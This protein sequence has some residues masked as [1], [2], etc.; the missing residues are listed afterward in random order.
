MLGWPQLEKNGR[1]VSHVSPGRLALTKMTAGVDVTGRPS[2]AVDCQQDRSHR[3]QHYD[4]NCKPEYRQHT[5]HSWRQAMT[6]MTFYHGGQVCN[7]C[8]LDIGDWKSRNSVQCT[9]WTVLV[10]MLTPATRHTHKR[11][12]CWPG[13]SASYILTETT[14]VN[15]DIIDTEIRCVCVCVQAL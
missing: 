8:E 10:P 3:L 11:D 7:D 9:W 6:L 12:D 13:I 4:R 1:P 14:E 2:L 15:G 5:V